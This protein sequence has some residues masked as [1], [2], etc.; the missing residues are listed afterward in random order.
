MQRNEMGRKTIEKA[1]FAWIIG[2]V[3]ISASLNAQPI[4]LKDA[5]PALSFNRPLF[6]THAGDGTNRLFVV[7]QDG[8]IK[9]FPNDSTTVTAQT[10]LDISSK[11]SSPGGEEGLLGLAFHPQYAANGYFFVNYTAP[12]PLRTVISRF[13]V[14]DDPSA[15]GTAEQVILEIPQPYSNHNGGMIAFGPDGYFYIGTGDGGDVG[16]PLNNGQSLTT[17]L[18]K[19]LRIDISGNTPGVPYL[20]PSD[21]PFA[22]NQNGYREEIWAYGFRNPWRF[23]FDRLTGQLW[24]GDVGQGAREEVDIIEKGKNYGWRI[25]EGFACYDPSTGCDQTGLTLPVLDYDHSVGF[26]ITGGYVYHGSARP[27]LEGAY[28]YADFGTRKI[29]AL[30]LNGTQVQSDS[31]LLVAA[32]SIASF[33]EDEAGELYVVARSSTTPTHIFRFNDA[34]PLPVQLASFRAGLSQQ[35][36]HVSLKWST[37]S[38]INNYGFTVQRKG[39]YDPAFADLS[40]AFLAGKG[41]TIEPQSYSY[42]DTSI[43]KAGRYSY[44]LK[45][46]DLDGGIHF[47]HSVIIHVTVTDVVEV[48]PRV[49]HLSQ[50][51]PNPFNPSTTIRY[52]L[53]DRSHVTLRV[54]NTLGQEVALLENGEQ[55]AGYHEVKFGASGLSSGV[56]FYRIQVR[57]LDSVIGRD[58]KSGAGSFMETKKLLLT[59]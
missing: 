46:Q 38:E 31:L 57:P 36:G 56:Y 6:L 42:V 35:G 52:G 30:R 5:F 24:A 28:I 14:S 20:I 10:F 12:D 1:G 3:C 19:I 23:S 44:R 58:S 53:P 54:F 4:Q 17:L 48:A 16:D 29:W 37:V 39:E 55:E 32:N 26:S 2:S 13:H 43:T 40:D 9:V 49:F 8:I 33:G 51:Y 59:Q 18:G 25:M 47:T 27:E 22:G 15:S 50:N 21:N 45:Q 11:I 34:L 7:Q 41:T